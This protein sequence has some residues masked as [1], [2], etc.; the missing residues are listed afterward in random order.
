MMCD[1]IARTN[2]S[3]IESNYFV[4][5]III[6]NL[7]YYMNVRVT[8]TFVNQ[9]T[10]CRAFSLVPPKN[11]LHK[12]RAIFHIDLYVFS[13]HTEVP[14]STNKL[15]HMKRSAIV[16]NKPFTFQDSRMNHLC[17]YWNKCMLTIIQYTF[18][19][20]HARW[21]PLIKERFVIDKSVT[22]SNF[23]LTWCEKRCC[24]TWLNLPTG[25][26]ASLNKGRSSGELSVIEINEALLSRKQQ[27]W[28]KCAHR[29]SYFDFPNTA[30]KKNS[31]QVYLFKRNDSLVKLCFS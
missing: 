4:N 1:F 3:N 27:S 17:Q 22:V 15:Y 29:R 25:D 23:F 9:T 14:D 10:M 28:Q 19:N 2:W 24:L 18:C 16:Q 13:I 11:Y 5:T 12:S 21:L 20:R 6:F 31:T 26:D 7:S 30:S 8:I